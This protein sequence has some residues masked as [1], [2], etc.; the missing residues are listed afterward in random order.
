[1]NE[2]DSII[3]RLWSVMPGPAGR[4]GTT[5]QPSGVNGRG[6]HESAGD[7]DTPHLF[8]VK[9]PSQ[10]D[11]LMRVCQGHSPNFAFLPPTILPD[12]TRGRTPH[13]EK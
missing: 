5:R 13:T 2:R 12:F 6:R 9:S 3:E 7:E 4:L 10:V 11:S 8:L 1:M